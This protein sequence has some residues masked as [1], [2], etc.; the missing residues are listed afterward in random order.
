VIARLIAKDPA[1]RFASAGDVLAALRSSAASLAEAAKPPARPVPP[2]TPAGRSGGFQ[3]VQPPARPAADV[4]VGPAAGSRVPPPAPRH[5]PPAAPTAAP[6]GG[7]MYLVRLRNKQSG[8][9][10]LATLQRQ[11]RA[12][13]VSRLHQIST[14]GTTWRP[15]TSIDGLF[16]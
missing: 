2:N 12:G 10:D 7:P 3:S 8:P 5:A 6:A 16:S 13:L 1:Q 11:A 14:D 15:A 9:F 4:P